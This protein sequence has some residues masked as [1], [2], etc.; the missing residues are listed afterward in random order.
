[1]LIVII[2]MFIA[3]VFVCVIVVKNPYIQSFFLIEKLFED[4]VFV[5]TLQS[6]L[7]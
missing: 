3:F 2:C 4:I 6:I 5:G 1:M 7:I